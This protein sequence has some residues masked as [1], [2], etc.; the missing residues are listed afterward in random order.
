MN[1][2][3]WFDGLAAPG[4]LRGTL[5]TRGPRIA[6]WVLALALAVQAAAIVTHLAG[7]GHVGAPKGGLPAAV[8]SPARPRVDIAAIANSHLF[9]AAQTAAAQADAANA[10]KTSMPLVLSGIIAARDPKD[11]MAILGE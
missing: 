9:G 8:P 6:L 7:A 2:V 3:S 10:P 1:A 11:G 5:Q 4:K